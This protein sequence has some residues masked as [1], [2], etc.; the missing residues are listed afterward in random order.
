MGN[1]Q[2]IYAISVRGHY[3]HAANP[4][5][6]SIEESDGRANGSRRR[7]VDGQIFN[8]I[9]WNGLRNHGLRPLA[10][11]PVGVFN[12]LT[13]RNAGSAAPTSID[14]SHQDGLLLPAIWAPGGAIGAIYGATRRTVVK[15]GAY[16]VVPVVGGASR[17][18]TG[19]AKSCV[20]L[21]QNKK[22]L[23]GDNSRDAAQCDLCR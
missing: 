19:S 20:A 10:S 23:T 16:E 2:H 4:A 22:S 14:C 1:V 5:L 15:R 7:S 11:R 13:D 21:V 12:G 9:L 17:G 8:A 18:A 3:L 6:I